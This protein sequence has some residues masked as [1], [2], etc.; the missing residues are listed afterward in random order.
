MNLQIVSPQK[1]FYS[2]EVNLVTL[3]GM[4]GEFTVL[5]NHA[6]LI[7]ALNKGKIVYR[8]QSAEH[9]LKIEGGFAE[10][11]NNKVIVC[12]ENAL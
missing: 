7:T 12:V 2:G 5:E 6:P 1:V 9:T 11:N 3:P 10:V 8:L 4:L